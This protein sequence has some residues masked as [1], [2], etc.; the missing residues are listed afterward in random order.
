VLIANIR[1]SRELRREP[2]RR[3]INHPNFLPC[4]LHSGDERLRN[5]PAS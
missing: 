3:M 1:I 5:L 4:I 2:T